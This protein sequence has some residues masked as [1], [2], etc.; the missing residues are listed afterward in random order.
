MSAVVMPGAE[1]T[2]G[3]VNV[4]VGTCYSRYSVASVGGDSGDTLPD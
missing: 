2:I 4:Y 1:I 3:G